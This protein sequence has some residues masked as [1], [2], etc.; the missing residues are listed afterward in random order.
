MGYTAHLLG[1]TGTAKQGERVVSSIQQP[2]PVAIIL[3]Q[4]TIGMVP[5]TW[6]VRLIDLEIPLLEELP[7][8]RKCLLQALLAL[9]IYIGNALQAGNL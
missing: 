5:S 2:R 6:W 4:A 3:L 7:I 8:Q 1:Q 9:K